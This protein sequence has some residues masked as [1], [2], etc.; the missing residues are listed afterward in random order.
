MKKCYSFFVLMLLSTLYAIAQQESA[1]ATNTFNR[2]QT[3][4]V[5]LAYSIVGCVAVWKIIEAAIS[6]MAKNKDQRTESDAKELKESILRV[7]IG[8]AIV[9]GAVAIGSWIVSAVRQ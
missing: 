7:V 9:F 3:V 2:V 8:C 1:A 5:A 4:I 6:Y